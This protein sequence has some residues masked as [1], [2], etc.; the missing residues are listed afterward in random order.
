MCNAAALERTQK[1]HASERQM[2]F[3]EQQLQ[4]L[5]AQKSLDG[6]MVSQAKL[7][8]SDEKVVQATVFLRAALSAVKG[9]S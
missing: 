7:I 2:A 4:I 9:Q 3:Q 6:A 1:L 5:S 8:K